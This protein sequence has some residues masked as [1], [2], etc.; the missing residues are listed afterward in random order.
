VLVDQA[1]AKTD[2]ASYPAKDLSL[3]GGPADDIEHLL[4]LGE[5]IFKRRLQISRGSFE[6]WM[7]VYQGIAANFYPSIRYSLPS[8]V[9]AGTIYLG[10]I[11]LHSIMKIDGDWLRRLRAE[12]ALDVEPREI[13]KGAE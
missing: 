4:C 3:D 7:G 8:F 10:F 6:R 12:R 13:M 1:V 9:F 11:R 2:S 5:E